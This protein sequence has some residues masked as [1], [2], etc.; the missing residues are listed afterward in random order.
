[1]KSKYSLLVLAIAFMGTTAFAGISAPI[2]HGYQV[3]DPHKGNLRFLQKAH[4]E[5]VIDHV[6]SLGYEVYGPEG[7]Q[8]ELNRLGFSFA[9]LVKPLK[10]VAQSYPSPEAIIQKMVLL[11]KKYPNLISLIEIGKTVEGRSLVFAK[12]TA[13]GS[14]NRPEFK[15]VANMHGDE[16]VGREMMVMLI[17][18]LASNYGTDARVTK[19]LQ[20]FQIYIMP[21]M[22]PDGAFHRV[23]QNAHNVDLNRS[24]PDFT[25]SDN[26]NTSENR[27]PEIQAMMNF[28]SKHQ[29]KLSANF[30]GGSEVVN[31]PWDAQAAANPNDAFF[32][33]ISLDY[34][35]NV[36]Y[37]YNS[38]EFPQGITNG[39]A[40]YQVLGGMQDWSNHWYND[41]QVT[42]E[43]T[44]TKYP[45]Y[46][47]VV[48]TYNANREALVG[49]IEQMY[50]MP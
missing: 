19:L 48:P 3:V 18:D 23:R 5:F 33:K 32:K 47:A 11:Q 42:I 7:M 20:S 29:F 50:Q 28:Q 43:L 24:F 41:L 45:D 46:S 17:E 9:P 13:P 16:I 1:M 38:S 40:W 31:Y 14:A 8:L 35:K 21:S 10:S 30:H 22:N 6:T 25:T 27:E 12:V 2:T 26:V 39:Y 34:A 37:I 36:P 44:G 15:Y 49:Y 4:P